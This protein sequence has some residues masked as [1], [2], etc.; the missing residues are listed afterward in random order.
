MTRVVCRPMPQDRLH[1]RRLGAA[2]DARRRDAHDDNA[3][4][5]HLI[6]ASMTA[7]AV[8]SSNLPTP[9]TTLIGREREAAAVTELLLRPDVR[10]ITLTGPGGIGKTRLA[11]RVAAEFEANFAQEL[12]WVTLGAVR[13]LNLVAST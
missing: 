2:I 11:L 13:D 12:S 10:L 4:S 3:L 5:S 8:C 9:L 7:S 1:V 6:G